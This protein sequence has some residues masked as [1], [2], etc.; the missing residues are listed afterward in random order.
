MK[1]VQRKYF[2]LKMPENVEHILEVTEVSVYKWITY[3]PNRFT[4]KS[5]F[6]PSGYQ[7]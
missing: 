6:K 1:C 4:S 2:V 5:T 7:V 3:F